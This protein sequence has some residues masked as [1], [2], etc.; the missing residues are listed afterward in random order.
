MSLEFVIILLVVGV[1]SAVVTRGVPQDVLLRSSD[2]AVTRCSK[3]KQKEVSLFEAM[4]FKRDAGP[5][6]DAFETRLST[7]LEGV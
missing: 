1:H 7:F 3:F 6:T 4:K 2:G 5:T